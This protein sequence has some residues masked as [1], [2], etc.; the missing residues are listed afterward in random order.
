MSAGEFMACIVAAVFAGFVGGYCLAVFEERRRL[1]TVLSDEADSA[2][3]AGFE[4]GK[5]AAIR[6]TLTSAVAGDKNFKRAGTGR[7]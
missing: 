3:E 7:N 5:D 2:F 1:Q 4:A 6:H